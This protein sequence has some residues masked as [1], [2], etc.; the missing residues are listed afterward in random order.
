ML[1]PAGVAVIEVPYVRDMVERT[2]FDTI[3]H[4]H[5]CYFSVPRRRRRWS[6]VTGWCSSGWSACRFTAARLRLFISRGERHGDTTE[7]LLREEDGARAD[8]ARRT[9]VTSARPSSG[10]ATI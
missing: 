2:E 5:L 8:D 6:A 7:Q 10:C 3:Y 1:A 4:E 9:I